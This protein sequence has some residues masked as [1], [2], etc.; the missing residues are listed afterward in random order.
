M[1]GQGDNRSIGL[2]GR[3]EQA[4]DGGQGNRSVNIWGGVDGAVVNAGDGNQIT[5]RVTH[6]LPPPAQE[7]DVAAEIAGLRALM[8]GLDTPERG[9]MGRAM[10][11]AGEQAARPSPD[12]KKVAD[13]L[14]RAVAVSKGAA[15]FAG[16]AVAI[17]ERVVRIAG[18]L[19]PLAK[20]A[21]ALLGLAM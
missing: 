7:V 10:E 1:S 20:G 13:A 8:E 19:G 21:L 16:N 15:D 9:M 14:E 6:V 2:G 18:W 17:E 4:G 12:K 5:M 3:P 11:D